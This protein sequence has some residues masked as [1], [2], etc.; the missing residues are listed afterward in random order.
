MGRYEASASGIP[1]YH[2]KGRYICLPCK[3]GD[4]CK[5]NSNNNECECGCGDIS[6]SDW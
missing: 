4:H 2:S 5:G 1:V 6:E 3:G